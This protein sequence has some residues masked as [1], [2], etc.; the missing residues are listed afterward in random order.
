M[1]QILIAE[2]SEPFRRGLR[3]L[4]AATPGMAVVGEAGDGAAAIVQARELQPDVVLMDLNMPGV[5][6]IEATRR[7]LDTSPHIAVLVLT[8]HEDDES[9]FAAMRAGARGYLLKGAR[10]AEI[11]RAIQATADGEA[12]F[13]PAIARRLMG[14]FASLQQAEA[15]RAPFPELTERERE[16]LDLVASG[17][18]NS[19]IAARLGIADKTARNHIGNIFAK[20]QVADRA[21]AIIKARDAGMGGSSTAHPK[22]AQHP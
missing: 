6:G 13:S 21:E 12:L 1:I 11:L 19:Q 17:L 5:N 9:V 8:M 2:D 20:L 22:G 14:Y 7:I 18:N 10:K 4:L 3:A 15:R 16:V